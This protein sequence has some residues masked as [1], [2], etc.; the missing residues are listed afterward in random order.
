MNYHTCQLQYGL[1]PEKK[2][3]GC[4]ELS[5]QCQEQRARAISVTY[6]S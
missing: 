1:E 5:L 6:T 4:S 2:A 3:A